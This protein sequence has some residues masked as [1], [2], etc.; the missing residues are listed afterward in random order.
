MTVKIVSPGAALGGRAAA[1]RDAPRP[2]IGHRGRLSMPPKGY[3]AP[4]SPDGRAGIVPPPP[5]HYSGDFLIVEYRTDPGAVGALLPPELEPA[6][7]PGAVATIF[8]HWQSWS[9][10]LHELDNPI[11]AQY[12]EFFL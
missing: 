9:G 1:D 4:L 8:A 5:W 7:A 3:T 2:R 11:Q 6:E 10:K 12:R